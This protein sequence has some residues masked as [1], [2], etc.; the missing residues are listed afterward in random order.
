MYNSRDFFFKGKENEKKF[1]D[2]FE[3][4]SESSRSDDVKR[5]FDMT[6]ELK[7][8]FKGMKKINRTD[9]DFSNEYHWVEI[10]NVGGKKGWLF[11]DADLFV[12]EMK[13][14]YV[15]VWKTDLQQTIAKRIVKNYNSKGGLIYEKKPYHLWSRK[16]R[17][18]VIT[19]VP[20]ADLCAIASSII[21]KEDE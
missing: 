10:K 21:D 4:M 15:V 20:T 9:Q 13:N 17:Q 11:G 3:G 1:R 12:F 2:M 7:I 16:G 6:M 8:D 14:Y 19:M 18:D 5:K